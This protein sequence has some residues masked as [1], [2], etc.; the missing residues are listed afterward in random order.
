M[1]QRTLNFRALMHKENYWYSCYYH[2]AH[3]QSRNSVIVICRNDKVFRTNNFLRV[4]IILHHKCNPCVSVELIIFF[5]WFLIRAWLQTIVC[6][7]IGEFGHSNIR[8]DRKF[9]VLRNRVIK[10]FTTFAPNKSVIS[11][12]YLQMHFNGGAF[13]LIFMHPLFHLRCW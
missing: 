5:L 6:C 1:V 13:I 2:R 12:R 9:D 10:Y 7:F 8:I 4:Y 3:V 11:Q